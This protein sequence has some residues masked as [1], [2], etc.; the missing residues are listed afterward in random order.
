MKCANVRFLL[1]R[2]N[3]IVIIFFLLLFFYYF[4][5]S[6]RILTSVLKSNLI[7]HA[8]QVYVRLPV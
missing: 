5:L 7:F 2:L 4:T 8:F 1:K 3:V 6:L